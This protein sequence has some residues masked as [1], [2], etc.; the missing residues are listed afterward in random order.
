MYD[1]Q[2]ILTLES[3]IESTSTTNVLP[4]P[5]F[6]NEELRKMKV[7][8]LKALLTARRLRTAGNK[9]ALIHRL[10]ESYKSTATPLADD[11]L[12]APEG[13]PANSRWKQLEAKLDPVNLP[14][15][16][17]RNPT[18]MNVQTQIEKFDYAEQ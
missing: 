17:F 3:D 2:P 5:P 18:Q 16:R 1:E 15:S 12:Q 7:T 10:S 13:F 6:T 14:P 8:E 4:P 9:T 11:E